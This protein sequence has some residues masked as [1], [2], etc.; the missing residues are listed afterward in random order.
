MNAESLKCSKV[1]LPPLW[2]LKSSTWSQRSLPIEITQSLAWNILYLIGVIP[3]PF[4]SMPD[5]PNNQ[6]PS[7]APQRLRHCALQSQTTVPR[8]GDRQT[9][10]FLQFLNKR[11]NKSSLFSLPLNFLL[12]TTNI[13][14][15]KKGKK[16]TVKH[17]KSCPLWSS[18]THINHA[19]LYTC[20]VLLFWR[21][22]KHRPVEQYC[23]PNYFNWCLDAILAFVHW[24][25][26]TQWQN[27]K[28]IIFLVLNSNTVL[29][30]NLVNNYSQI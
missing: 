26:Y 15:F 19:E 14:S 27:K 4:P 3:L 25:L 20:Y 29:F 2:T 9:T 16:H 18:Y 28:G 7:Q 30:S 21:N 10:H 17:N 12:T 1:R 8:R 6:T 23:L 5:S 24:L 22:D 11:K 13:C